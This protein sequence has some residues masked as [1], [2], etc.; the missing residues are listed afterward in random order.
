MRCPEKSLCCDITV[1][2]LYGGCWPAR[3][4]LLKCEL[5]SEAF[6]TLQAGRFIDSNA[7]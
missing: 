2:Q 1:G 5:N 7:S 4:P 3:F 6:V